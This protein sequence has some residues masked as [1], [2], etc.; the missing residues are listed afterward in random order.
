M[1]YVKKISAIL[2]VFAILVVV[3]IGCKKSTSTMLSTLE[4]RTITDMANMT[5]SV[6][7]KIERV[8]VAQ[9]WHNGM[10]A[11]LGDGG[12]IV[13]TTPA[14]QII[15]WFRKLVPGISDIPGI[16][17]TDTTLN[18][19]MLLKTKPDIV[20]LPTGTD[21][22]AQK[23]RKTGIPVV[24]VSGGG[25]DFFARLPE[26]MLFTSK[27]MGENESVKATRY[28]AY[29]ETKLQMLKSRALRIPDEQKLTVVH[30]SSV[31]PSLKVDGRNSI[32]D[33]WIN[34]AGGINAASPDVEG[35][36]KEISMEQLLKWNPDVIIIAGIT[37][38]INAVKKDALWKKLKA[39]QNG[40]IYLNPKGVFLWDRG[41]PEEVLQIQWAA[42]TL[43]P[44]N[45][46]DVNI[47]RET[48][49]FY[50][51]YFNYNLTD[52]EV[53]SIMNPQE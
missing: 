47:K 3:V 42:K 19:E 14:V 40:R 16:F 38:I 39:M 36:M 30:F 43:Y 22:L 1:K 37:Q 18:L 49:S 52:N 31:S 9:P 24:Q 23:I 33:A 6:P 17:I 27:I 13:A 28:V 32:I 53:M 20:I 50:K 51:T 25:D 46:A 44:E 5:V 35:A 21:E 12:K 11:M 41:G 15:P 7:V 10:L 45:N 2:S 34:I 4:M 8:A 29:L 48:K 26:C